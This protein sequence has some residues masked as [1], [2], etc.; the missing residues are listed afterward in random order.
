MDMSC[1]AAGGSQE[2]SMVALATERSASSDVDAFPADLS[3][4][5]CIAESSPCVRRP[6]NVFSTTARVWTEDF[7]PDRSVPSSKAIVGTA[8]PDLDPGAVLGLAK[9]R[10]ASCRNVFHL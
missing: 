6:G 7:L 8:G 10:P 3:A 4:K 1:Y 5:L 2:W 9:Q